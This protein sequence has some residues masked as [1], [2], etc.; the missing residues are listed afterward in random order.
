MTD[1]E[2][3]DAALRWLARNVA[4]SQR[5][6][7]LRAAPPSGS[8]LVAFSAIDRS[9]DADDRRRDRVA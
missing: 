8:V 5:I 6:S 3:D 9:Q 7:A 2:P 4:W 1:T